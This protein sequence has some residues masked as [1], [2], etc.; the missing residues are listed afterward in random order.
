MLMAE[1]GNLIIRVEAIKWDLD[2]LDEI[3][4]STYRKMRQLT[5]KHLITCIPM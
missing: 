4:I 5:K 1:G 2:Y 3:I